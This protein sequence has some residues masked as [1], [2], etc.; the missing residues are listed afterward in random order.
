MKKRL[1]CAVSSLLVLSFITAEQSSALS[2]NTEMLKININPD[3]R[4]HEISP[5][6]YGVNSGADLD[7]VKAKSI[8]L[9]G[10][11]M[12]AYNWENNFSNAGSDWHNTSDSYMIQ[13]LPEEYRKIPGA[14]AVYTG[15]EAEKHG[16]PFMLTT[17]Q[18]LGYVSRDGSGRMFEKD[19]VPSDRWVKVENRKN[20]EFS[21]TPDTS[22]DTVYMDEYINYLIQ[23]LGNSGSG[24]IKGY[25]L[26]NEP[27]LWNGTHSLIRKEQ[28]SVS[29]L[30][31]KSSSLASAVKDLDPQAL[32]FGPSLYGYNAYVSF[33]NAPDW[34]D[35][36]AE[37]GY[38][39]FIDCYLDLMNKESEKAGKR[40]L[41]VLD[42]HYY[43]EARGVCNQR[44]CEHYDNPECVRAR[45][46]STRSLFDAEYRENSWITDTGA[47][48]LPLL[49]NIKSSVERYYPGTLIAVTEYDFGSRNH[50]SGAIAQADALGI[51]A[52]N[53][54]FFASV[55]SFD[56]NDYQ[57]GAINMFTDYDGNGASFGNTLIESSI[58]ESAEMSVYASSND[59]SDDTLTAIVTNKSMNSDTPVTINLSGDV[60]YS[61]ADIYGITGDSPEIKLLADNIGITDNSLEFTVPSLSVTEFVFRTK[62]KGGINFSLIAAVSAGLTV[63]L[64]AFSLVLKIRI[65]KKQKH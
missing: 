2:E 49:P 31:E 36:K 26:D 41:D 35:I 25:S 55:W 60:S 19:A 59:G 32:V 29:E 43:T 61:S 23:N 21:L 37:S 42:I 48:F 10:N 44:Y 17:L 52:E 5:Y 13:T 24:G 18:M 4:L 9:G 45:L 15:A 64:A 40:L 16:I 12:S 65:S 22:D 38:N 51:F 20:A 56:N 28:L 11:R 3:N 57:F 6:I 30:I 8:R 62:I 7:S 34:Q 47:E 46:D 39:W 58:S 53:D 63:I 14:P 54:V 27:G 33:Q 1:M 50:I